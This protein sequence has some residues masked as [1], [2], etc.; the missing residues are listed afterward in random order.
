M[1]IRLKKG[2]TQL[3]KFD[4]SYGLNKQ[5]KLKLIT[6]TSYNDFDLPPIN[7]SSRKPYMDIRLK[8]Y[9]RSHNIVKQTNKF[10]T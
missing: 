8:K 1:D 6:F 9:K 10:H 7:L 2:S 5:Q 4:K 3:D